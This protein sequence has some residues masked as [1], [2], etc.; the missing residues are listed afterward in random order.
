MFLLGNVDASGLSARTWRRNGRRRRAR[1]RAGDARRVPQLRPRRIPGLAA[2]ADVLPIDM[3]RAERQ[4]FGDP[5]A[6]GPARARA[7]YACCPIERGGAVASDHAHRR[8]RRRTPQLWRELPPLD[9]A[10]RFD[11]L[12]LKPTA[13]V[14][15]EGDDPSRS[16][17]LVL[18]GWG[19]GRTAALGGRLDVALAAGRVR[20][21]APPLLA[22]VRAVAGQ[23]GRDGRRA[24]VGAARPAAL[25]A[26][27]PRR[28]H[29]RRRGRRR[30]QP[31]EDGDVRG[32]HREAR[33]HRSRRSSP[34]GAA[35]R[36]AAASP[37]RRRRA[38]TASRS[39]RA[40]AANR[41]ARRRRGSACR[42]RTSS[43]TSP[44]PSRRCWRRSR[45]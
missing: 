19:D 45:D 39:P 15:A 32:A 34:R 3:G 30:A 11:R 38:T 44:R 37:T 1:R 17:L 24:R 8:R 14:V 36:R 35:T 40:T 2:R 33:R 21:G 6:R 29:A 28:L 7:A 42:T 16:P 12:R 22:A 5:P 9:G 18:V 25:P 26:R 20:R 27:Q 41:S 31:L 4:N 23:E 43:S 10:N 13:E